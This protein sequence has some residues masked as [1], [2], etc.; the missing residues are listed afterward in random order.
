M[1]GRAPHVAFVLSHLNQLKLYLPILE[2]AGQLGEE[3]T[4]VLLHKTDKSDN[5]LRN[6][7]E[8]KGN[9]AYEPF[10]EEEDLHVILET[11]KVDILITEDVSFVYLKNHV[12]GL[13]I[14][15]LQHSHDIISAFPSKYTLNQLLKID[16]FLVFSEFWKEK[17]IK[18]LDI[19][20]KDYKSDISEI[21]KRTAPVGFPELEQ[22]KDFS[23]KI[24]HKKYNIKIPK[25]GIIF[26]DPIG[27]VNHVG[28]AYYGYFFKLHGSVGNKI[29]IFLKQF[30]YD[31]YHFPLKIPR[32]IRLIFKIYSS[33]N[34]LVNY[35]TLVEQLSE[36]CSKND[37][38][39][40][41][42]SRKKN[43]DPSFIKDLSD[44]YSFDLDYYP[45][46]LLELLF[47]SN[48]YI[49]FNSTTTLEAISCGSNALQL[50]V[51]PEEFQYQNY[52]G[53]IYQYLDDTL[54]TEFSWNNYPGLIE[55]VKHSKP[56]EEL[57]T[58]F[59]F[60]V[61]DILK[62]QYINKF[63]MDLNNSS[64]RV[65]KEINNYHE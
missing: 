16:K 4:Y 25:G 7:I 22:I 62:D 60:E 52:A 65:I 33:K 12:A 27:N 30:F 39:L 13:K 32:I 47:I 58:K 64:M 17:F 28:N 1:P 20:Y 26:L 8:A 36:Y 2:K 6:R 56:M 31:F 19:R 49:G 11:T 5:A 44:Y 29:I 42:K 45:F 15:Y 61:E 10:T 9:V 59:N 54:S 34:L 38:L 51:C 63:L 21:E 41:I 3:N 35:Q 43:N 55:V 40:V 48:F 24:I 57:F 14:F 50:N 23:K 53:G 37:A 46:T 18:T